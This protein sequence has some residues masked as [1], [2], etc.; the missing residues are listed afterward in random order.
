M[1]LVYQQPI[2]FDVTFAEVLQISA[3]C[4]IS[5]LLR[6]GRAFLQ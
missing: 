1:N 6:H 2:R 3:K 5:I 4:M